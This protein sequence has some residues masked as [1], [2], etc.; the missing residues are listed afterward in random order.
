MVDQCGT[1]GQNLFY[2]QRLTSGSGLLKCLC[3]AGNEGLHERECQKN[4]RKT[5]CADFNTPN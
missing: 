5:H 3:V 4:E 2:K 1:K